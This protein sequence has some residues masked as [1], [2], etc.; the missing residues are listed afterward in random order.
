MPFLLKQ[1]RLTVKTKKQAVEVGDIFRHYGAAYREKYPLTP[2]QARVLSALSACRTAQLGG[3]VEECSECGARQICY[4]SCRDRHCPKCEK[5]RRAQWIENQKVVLLPIPY[6]HLTFTT[7]HAINPLIPANQ[8][9]IYEALFWAVSQTLQQFGQKYLGGTLGITAVLHT[10]GQQM[11]PHVHLHCIVSGGALSADKQHWHKS[12]RHYL[13]DV[14]KLSAAYRDRFC[15]RLKRLAKA[16]KLKLVGACA[17]LDV[18]AMVEQMGAKKWEVFAK[19]FDDPQKVY[20]YLSRYVHQ[21]AISNH[22]IVKLEK[23]Q[24][25]FE[26]HDNKDGGKLKVLTLPAVEFIRRFVWHVLPEGFTRIRHYGLHHSSARKAKLPQAR[27]HLG[28]EPAVPQA[29][30]LEL[31]AWLKEILGADELDRCPSCGQVN[32]MF[33]RTEFRH[34][35]WWQVLVMTLLGLSLVGTVQR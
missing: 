32:T 12:G 31:K 9:V 14:I 27:Q 5:F 8:Q 15:R 33:R 24:V 35:S 19:P 10:W 30:K 2:Q 34:L 4:C 7:D 3:Y 11:D 26:Y 13:V 16:G 17:G 1:S 20:E 6:F 22:R 25:S 23:G 21:V 29:H 28:L 18:A